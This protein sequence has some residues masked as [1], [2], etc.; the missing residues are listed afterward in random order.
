[1]KTTEILKRTWNAITSTVILMAIIWLPLSLLSVQVNSL[2][3]LHIYPIPSFALFTII[4]LAFIWLLT[5]HNSK[6]DR[7]IYIAVILLTVALALVRYGLGVW[8]RA[9]IDYYY[10]H[11]MHNLYQT[12]I[13]VCC[14]TVFIAGFLFETKYYNLFSNQSKVTS[15]VIRI[16]K[17]IAIFLAGAIVATHIWSYLYYPRPKKAQQKEIVEKAEGERFFIR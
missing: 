6:R 12:T 10:S 7:Y 11:L 17:W 9:N 16:L 14:A 3:Y 2:Y 5:K 15:T 13:F 8:Y 4:S 1:M